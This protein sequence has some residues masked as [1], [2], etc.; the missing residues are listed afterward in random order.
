MR[1]PFQLVTPVPANVSVLAAVDPAPVKFALMVRLA[2]AEL[3]IVLTIVHGLGPPP[4]PDMPPV[5]VIAEEPLK[6]AITAL[7]I[8]MALGMLRPLLLV[9]NIAALLIVMPPEK[10]GVAPGTPRKPPLTVNVPEKLLPAGNIHVP[11]LDLVTDKTAPKSLR[12]RVRVFASA[13]TPVSVSV[14]AEVPA[15]LVKSARTRGPLPD[16]SMVVLA[17]RTTRR[18]AVSPSPT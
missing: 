18:A 2:P 14:R 8:V 6:P 12:G 10:L 13:L 1:L 17:V 15:A 3:S 5:M 9:A 7:L 11:P 4:A 16:E